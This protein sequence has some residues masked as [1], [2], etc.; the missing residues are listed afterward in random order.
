MIRIVLA[1]SQ[2]LTNKGIQQL[3]LAEQHIH[4]TGSALDIA[5]LKV[6]LH[7]DY[8]ILMVDPYVDEHFNLDKIRHLVNFQKVIVITNQLSRSEITEAIDLGVLIYISKNCTPQE[9]LQAIRCSSRNER[10]FCRKTLKVLYG[11]SPADIDT[12]SIPAL[13][14]RE[15]EI[16]NLIALGLS[17]RKIA[18]QLYLSFHTIRTHRKN[19]SKKIGFS[20]KNAAQLVWLISYLN[21]LL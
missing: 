17:D 20:L 15:T 8:D 16:I 5:A 19:I 21:D 6:C 14:Y 18:F 4:L 1:D 12:N 9:I 7:R 13:T 2:P 10:F 11:D 3:L